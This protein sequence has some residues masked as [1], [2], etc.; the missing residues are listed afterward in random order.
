MNYGSVVADF[1]PT[2]NQRAIATAFSRNAQLLGRNTTL[3]RLYEDGGRRFGEPRIG[4]LVAHVASRQAEFGRSI[5]GAFR[6]GWFSPATALVRSVLEMTAWFA[7][8]F[9]TSDEQEQR[10]RLIRLL[11]QGYRDAQNRG[12]KLPPDASE[13]LVTTT[14]KAARKPVDFQQMLKD[15]DELERKTEGGMEYWVS[16]AANF[17]WASQHVHP[18]LYGP[19]TSMNTRDPDELVGVNALVHGHQ[20]LALCAATCAIAAGL[21]DLKSEVEQRY[22]GVVELQRKELERF[23]N[24]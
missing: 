8:P 21:K 9:A 6:T 11:L 10:K 20:Y 4:Q 24:S 16:H 7:W 18:S 14:G 12:V 5:V 3:N 19:L 2:S 22:E 23:T 17:E 13:L 1:R 15:L